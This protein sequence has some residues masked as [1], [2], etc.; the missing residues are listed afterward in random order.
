MKKLMASASVAVLFLHACS[1]ANTDSSNEASN[2]EGADEKLTIMTSIFPLEDWT[3][4]IGG[5]YV[6][7][8]NVVPVGADAHSYEPT[9]NE[10][11]SVAE[12]DAF[13]YNGAG[14]EAFADSIV[15]AVENQ[16][17]KV[18]EAS[19]AVD[20]IEDNHDHDHGD[21][22]DHSQSDDVHDHGDE[23]GHDDDEHAHSHDHGEGDAGIAHIDGLSDHYHSGDDVHL[24]VHEEEE[25]GH[26][27]W[28]WYTLAPD[29]NPEDEEAW[30]VVPDN[31]TDTYEGMAEEDGQQIQAKLFGDDHDVIAQSEPVTISIDD[32]DDDHGHDHGHSHG[33]YD[34]HVW[35]DP[36]LS[37]EMA[38]EIKTLLV[39]LMPEQEAY[40][41][42]NFEA[43]K[44]EFEELDQ[45]FQD[46]AERAEKD[47]F[48]VSHA[49]YGYWENRYGINQIGIA[50][51]SP[52]SE[53]SQ[54]QLVK[55]I[56]QAE[57]LGLEYV[58]FEP[59]ITPSVAQT[60]QSHLGAEARFIHPLEALTEEDVEAGADYFSLMHDNIETLRT[61]LSA[62]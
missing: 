30:E 50:G 41:E 35:L 13:I 46:L 27:H 18:L 61:A 24:T 45:S 4:K 26:D 9:P 21:G 1:N 16:D 25:S 32:H 20:L 15:S 55:T 11:I 37:I 56:E 60:V 22:G 44:T 29:A 62:N 7:V 53:P 6:D 10:M 43:L 52:T 40:F 19:G 12:A 14:I 2:G 49:G 28:H 59:N 34:P 54:S 31:G 36:V 39:E 8:T 42:D 51:I 47:T 38:E 23:D 3:K 48:I 5:D 57:E 33:D 17:V 58:L